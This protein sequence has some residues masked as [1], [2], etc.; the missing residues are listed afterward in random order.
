MS[1]S[2]LVRIWHALKS[3][4]KKSY[5]KKLFIKLLHNLKITL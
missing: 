5:A 3:V 4:Y 2:D 1:L